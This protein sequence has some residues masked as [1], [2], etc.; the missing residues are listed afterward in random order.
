VS[1]LRRRLPRDAI[2]AADITRL[3]Y[4][5]LSEF[6]V[7]QPRTFLH[8]AGFVAMGYGLPAAL[9][10]RAAF[11][12]RAIV[13]VVGDGCFL[14]SGMELA[15]A[16]QERLPVVVILVNDESLTL[17]KLIQE[18]RYEGRYL[19]VDLKNPDFALFAR[20]F[21]VRAW[22]V[23][24]DAAFDQALQEALAANEPALIEVRLR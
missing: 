23:D 22:Q 15:T 12:D 10:A 19:G 2:V 5:L 18:R 7:Y 4:I 16:V 11:P 20:A 8:P 13:A 3:S 24:S 17:I 6:P 21:G 1:A 14:M 9:G